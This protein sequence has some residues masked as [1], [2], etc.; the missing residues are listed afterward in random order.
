[1]NRLIT[2]E[3]S[4]KTVKSLSIKKM[5]LHEVYRRVLFD[6]KGMISTLTNSITYWTKE[7]IETPQ[8]I[9]EEIKTKNIQE[10]NKKS[11][12]NAQKEGI[13]NIKSNI[14]YSVG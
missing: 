12:E 7:T 2:P 3:E 6:F 9:L 5:Q 11:M 14:S 10:E 13:E 8:Q 1:M 4:E